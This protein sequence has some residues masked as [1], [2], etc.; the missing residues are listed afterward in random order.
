MGWVYYRLGDF[1]AAVRELELAV[2]LSPDDPTIYE[3]LGDAY[4]K[5]NDHAKAR[6]AYVK[7][8]ALHEEEEKKAA[9]RSKL[10]ALPPQDG[11][12]GGAK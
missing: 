10:E 11:Q 12:T 2:A 5:N 8:L 3:H 6:Q 4:L 1:P 7:S 9:V